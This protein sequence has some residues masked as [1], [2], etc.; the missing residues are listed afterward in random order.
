MSGVYWGLSAM[1]L[2]G[3][4]H[5]MGTDEIVEWVLS[6]QDRESGGFAGNV[7]HDAHSEFLLPLRLHVHLTNSLALTYVCPPPVNGTL[8]FSTRC[9]R[10]KF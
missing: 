1:A 6:C 7:G 4:E 3:R 8:Q 10:F 2:M 9:R 5:E